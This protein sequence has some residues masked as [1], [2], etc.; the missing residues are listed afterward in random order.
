[1]ATSKN[2]INLVFFSH[3]WTTT[4]YGGAARYLHQLISHM[5]QKDFNFT[6]FTC[7][8][9]NKIPKK[10]KALLYEKI[11]SLETYYYKTFPI[12][13]NR[14]HFPTFKSFFAINNKIKEFI[15]Q[16]NTVFVFNNR[17]YPQH[18]LW[19]IC[20]KKIDKH[21]KTIL[22][23]HGDKYWVLE[24]PIIKLGSILN[25]LVFGKYLI[26]NADI[27]ISAGK[28]YKNYLGKLGRP[29]YI[30]IPNTT[31]ILPKA[32][33][34]HVKGK[35]PK[36]IKILYLGRLYPHKHPYQLAVAVTYLQN[37]YKNISLSV[38][39]DGPEKTKIKKLAKKYK[40]IK[41]H[42]AIPHHKVPAILDKHHILALYSKIEGLPTSVIEALY[43]DLIVATTN[44]GGISQ[45]IPKKYLLDATNIKTSTIF[46]HLKNILDN[47]KTWAKTFHKLHN[48]TIKNY[49]WNKNAQKFE[50]IVKRL[51]KN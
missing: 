13:K 35:R 45:L 27:V 47:Y 6:L 48:N 15:K 30:V 37:I 18:A 7:G 20:I 29:D 49:T 44:A 28:S 4:D 23:T 16:K 1:M 10:G 25:E 41:V 21:A 31:N 24:N 11:S 14:V 17:F 38:I 3:F 40:F 46:T 42:R 51:V 12:L 43:R 50:R 36:Q 26:Q 5:Q 39:G 2:K 19:Y 34:I 22:I 33:Q 9:K 32:K 8:I